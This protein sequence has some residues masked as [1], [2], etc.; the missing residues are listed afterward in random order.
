MNAIMSVFVV[1]ALVV[2]LF[3]LSRFV[4]YS[5]T[6]DGGFAAMALMFRWFLWVPFIFF[7]A[8]GAFMAWDR[9]Q[10]LTARLGEL[11]KKDDDNAA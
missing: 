7:P 10:K 1:V 2:G 11:G 6:P 8:V 5:E 4:S 9:R 3:I